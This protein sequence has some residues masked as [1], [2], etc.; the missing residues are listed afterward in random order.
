MQ[1]DMP[2][3]SPVSRMSAEQAFERDIP[4]ASR[5]DIQTQIEEAMWYDDDAAVTILT[6]ERAN[7]CNVVAEGVITIGGR[8]FWFHAESGDYNGFVLRG[9]EEAGQEYE[10]VRRTIWVLAP[11]MRLVYTRIQEGRG[12]ALLDLWGGMLKQP[13]L[14][15]LAQ[16]YAYDRYMQPGLVV[17]SYWRSRAAERGFEIVCEEE[18]KERRELLVKSLNNRSNEDD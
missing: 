17:E 10:P 2:E 18:A 4:G 15:D 5:D 11:P 3:G 14:A 12:Q 6:K 1:R 9:W 13:D 16:K 7:M 8:E